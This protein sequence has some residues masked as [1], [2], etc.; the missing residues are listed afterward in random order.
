MNP[1]FITIAIHDPHTLEV[2]FADEAKSE[3]EAIDSIHEL[4]KMA[5]R[6]N[7]FDFPAP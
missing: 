4:F 1:H 6:N 7:V 3:S 5:R 2:L